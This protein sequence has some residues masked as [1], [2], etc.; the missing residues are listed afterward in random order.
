MYSWSLRLFLERTSLL[1]S[2]RLLA[3]FRDGSRKIQ[4]PVSVLAVQAD[5][6]QGRP[7]NRSACTVLCAL[8]QATT[9]LCTID[10]Q[11]PLACRHVHDSIRA[12]A[13]PARPR[14]RSTVVQAQQR[15]TA[16]LEYGDAYASCMGGADSRKLNFVQS[17]GAF[18]L[19][20][21]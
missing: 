14:H 16:R 3:G 11:T 20:G 13:P 12:W 5:L 9:N 19:Q 7:L 10:M 15:S 4:D 1:G 2:W 18:K 21:V 17:V 6:A 8:S